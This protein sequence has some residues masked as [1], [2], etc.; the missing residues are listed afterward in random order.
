MLKIPPPSCEHVES[1]VQVEV[2]VSMKM[3]SNKLMNLV[4]TLG[5]QILKLVQI[6]LNI[7][8]VG[9]QNIRFPLHQVFTLYTSDLTEIV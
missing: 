1:L 7:E 5:V 8:T 4:F 2:K 9:C 3:S 6:S